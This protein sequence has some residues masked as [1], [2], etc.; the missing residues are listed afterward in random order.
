MKK[1]PLRLGILLGSVVGLVAA[2][3]FYS[4]KAPK[5]KPDIAPQQA[6]L[7]KLTAPPVGDLAASVVKDVPTLI[8]DWESSHTFE[9]WDA[10]AAGLAEADTVE[11]VKA[12]VQGVFE[13]ADWEARVKLARNLKAVSNPEVLPIL[14]QALGM[15]FGRGSPVVG[16]IC[17]AISRL[18]QPDT[19]EALAAM[20]WQANG[21]GVDSHKVIRAVAGIRNPAA[22]KALG[23]LAAD[24]TAAESLRAAAEAALL[25]MADAEDSPP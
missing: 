7:K 5:A 14:L 17:E 10:C 19:V 25:A 12:L 9:Q 2:L 20:H 24:E 16:E 4:A 21:L 6:P 22:R 18:A 11:S 13:T 1:Q 3:S 8:R 15:D 23:K